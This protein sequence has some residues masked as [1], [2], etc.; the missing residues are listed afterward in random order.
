TKF[1]V[2]FNYL[3]LKA[4][5]TVNYGGVYDFGAF[6]AENLGFTPLPNPS[7][8]GSTIPFPNLSP[9]QAYGAGLPGDFIQGLG[10]PSDSFSNK[11]LGLFWQDS[12]R[13]LRYFIP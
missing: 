12:W 11:P 5:F 8:P 2:D 9:V 10:S 4:I 13:G 7:S 6:S 3:P 1:G